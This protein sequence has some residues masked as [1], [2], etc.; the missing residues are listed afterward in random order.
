[1]ALTVRQRRFAEEFLVDLNAAAAAVRAGYSP[2]GSQV[3]GSRLRNNE[4]IAALIQKGMDR[5]S[6]RV[7]ITAD[8]VLREIARVALSDVRGLLDA[9]G[10]LKPLH[11]MA[12][13]VTASI[14]SFEVVTK[15]VP[16]S[17]PAEVEHVAKVKLCDKLRALD[18]LSKHLKLFSERV[19]HDVS[20]SLAEL[21]RQID[22]KSRGLPGQ[23]PVG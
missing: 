11:E 6:R 3:T 5:R 12:D 13:E 18:M 7:E 23:P 20:D 14:A 21:L 9:E 15:R 16:G 19:E 10:N 4:E 22:G 8:R 2:T 1:M 17:K